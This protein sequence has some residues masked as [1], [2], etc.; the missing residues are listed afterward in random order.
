MDLQKHTMIL[1]KKG[2]ETIKFVL[3]FFDYNYY[4]I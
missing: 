1:N 4:Y 3:I 2:S